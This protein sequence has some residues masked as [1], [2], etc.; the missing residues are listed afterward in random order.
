MDQPARPSILV[1]TSRFPYPPV[2]GD[3]LRIWT[4]IEH[5]A[6]R[7]DVDLFALY[8]REA[9][10]LGLSEVERV[11]RLVR[12]QRLSRRRQVAGMMSAMRNGLPLQV[13]L[14]SDPAALES[15]RA[16]ISGR[17]Y[18]VVLAHLVRTLGYAMAVPGQPVVLELTDA[19][20]MNY[21]RIRRPRSGQEAVYVAERARLR[22]YERQSLER[23]AAGVVVARQDAD[24]LVGLGAA[25]G[26]VRVITN[27]TDMRPSPRAGPHDP[28]LV[29][30]M[31]NLRSTQNAD[32][33]TY[34]A[35]TILPRL[36]ALRPAA[37][38]QV[39]GANPPRQV[40]ALDRLPGVQVTGPVT[41]MALRLGQACVSVCPMRYGAGVQNKVLESMAVGVPVVTTGQGLE[42]IDATPGDQILVADDPDE[43]AA[44]VAAVLADADL[45]DRLSRA[46][47]AFIEERFRWDR[48]MRQYQDLIAEVAA[49]AAPRPGE[50]P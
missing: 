26:K 22:E 11:C 14:Y 3:K 25:P 34:F 49:G 27:G 29:V 16:L 12:T 42:G 13:G 7:F 5:L 2:G 24:Y 21:E 36:R 41:D 10:L 30:F 6:D 47:S 20:S 18:D 9:D 32:M 45:R 28:E 33:A 23:V 15:A 19:I 46:G 17:H 37:R 39:I 31:G 35:Q 43:F 48:P 38:F 4:I 40:L 50:A 1:I 44:L 8:A